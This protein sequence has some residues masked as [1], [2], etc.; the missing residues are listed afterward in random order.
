MRRLVS[1]LFAIAI[2]T[3]S[4]LAMARGGHSSYG[5]HHS[6]HSGNGHGSHHSYWHGG[7]YHHS[8]KAIGVP[9]DSHGHIKRTAEAKVHFKK[10]HPCPSTGRSTGACLGYI[11]DHMQWQT[12]EATKLKD[13]T[14]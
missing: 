8:P 14:E 2:L 7:H 12:V 4:P 13:R 5:G 11:I 10:T 6:G 9:R 1:V 3:T